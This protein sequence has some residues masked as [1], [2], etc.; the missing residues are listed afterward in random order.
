MA[1]IAQTFALNPYAAEAQKLE[2]QRKYAEILQA[3]GLQ[4]GGKHSY[5][6]IEAPPS[7]A[8]A[9]AKGLQLGMSGFMQGRADRKYDDLIGR[10]TAGRKSVM[11][12]VV[13]ALQGTEAV[14]EVPGSVAATEADVQDREMGMN[15]GT[16]AAPMTMGQQIPTQ[17]G[18]GEGPNVGAPPQ[19]AVPGSMEA[20]NALMIGSEF[21]DLQAAGLGSMNSM[22]LEEKKLKNA[23][24]L[25]ASPGGPNSPTGRPGT[26]IQYYAKLKELEEEFPPVNGVDHPNVA[27]FKVLIREQEL[28]RLGDSVAPVSNTTGAKVGGGTPMGLPPEKELPYITEAGA[29]NA[30]GPQ[31][32]KASGDAFDSLGK[33]NANIANIDDAIA[34]IDEGAETG[35][36]YS[37][38]PSVRVASV[39]LDNVQKRM[40]LD[41]IGSVTF[42]ALSQGELDLALNTALPTK[43]SP[44][45][46]RKWLSKKK[47]AQQK[48]STYLSDAAIYLGK[49]GNTIAGW[50]EMKKPNG[51]APAPAGGGEKPSEAEWNAMTPK[52]RALWK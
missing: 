30:A 19:A 51:G 49:P 6:G 33:I 52:E 36:I 26:A 8:A 17:G 50:A 24:T 18:M 41:I 34:A 43:L 42:G 10:A 15:M 38:L 23:I 44:P 29:A 47:A 1:E 39:E 11:D 37:M 16:G 25:K 2:R 5:A 7:A 12:K 21:P 4:P 9:L 31:A 32:I 3:Q 22:A 40:G 13:A 27:Q 14:P 46:L 48:L 35:A 28:Q 45:D 20:A